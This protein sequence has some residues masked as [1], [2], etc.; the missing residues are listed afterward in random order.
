MLLHGIQRVAYAPSSRPPRVV[1][2]R[3]K[4]APSQIKEVPVFEPFEEILPLQSG[5]Y[6]Y[7]IDEDGLFRLIRGNTRSHAAMVSGRPACSAGRIRVSREG[8][9]V[10]VV[11]WSTDY[12]FSHEL[13][14]FAY[15]IDAFKNHPAFALSDQA[16]FQFHT[17]P[18]EKTY[19]STSVSPIDDP[20]EP[21]RRLDEEGLSE[22]VSIRFTPDQI[23]RFLGYAPPVPP[24]LHR[25]HL[26]QLVTVID[27]PE[28]EGFEYGDPAPHLDLTQTTIRPGKNNFVIDERGRLIIGISGHQILSGGQPVGG[29]GH[30]HFDAAGTVIKLDTNFSGHYRP[31]LT[32]EY[33]RYVYQVVRNHPLI[34][35]ADDARFFG[36]WFDEESVDTRV[37][38]FLREEIEA[39]DLR[40]DEWI[41]S[42]F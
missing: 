39:D 13:T 19:W 2:P 32:G 10:H 27:G 16:I 21:F 34:D 30:I 7:L 15:V 17:G 5:F 3:K 38:E 42:C 14:R 20:T 35:L 26:D 28:D 31:P 8:K 33:V 40:L 41:E 11:C 6:T 24:K 25:M 36:R 22:Q 23:A 4:R 12:R 29:A 1:H 18:T 9:T 37:I